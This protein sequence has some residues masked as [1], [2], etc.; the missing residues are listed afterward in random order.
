MIVPFEE[1]KILEK[2]KKNMFQFNKPSSTNGLSAHDCGGL[3][4]GAHL[5]SPKS[6]PDAHTM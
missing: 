6:D 5:P 1:C 3:W 2:V 4:A